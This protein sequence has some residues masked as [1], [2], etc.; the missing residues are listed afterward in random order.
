VPGF[1]II[2]SHVHIYDPTY[3]TYDWIRNVPRLNKPH[4]TTDFTRL[5]EGVEVDKIV[6]VE[7]DVAAGQHLDEARWVELQAQNGQQTSR[8]GSLD[9]T[10][11]R[12]SRSS[13]VIATCPSIQAALRASSGDFLHYIFDDFW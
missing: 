10:R 2:D 6:F 11:E 4:L 8:H 3:L 9:P 12:P 1:P 5:T 13:A 7:V